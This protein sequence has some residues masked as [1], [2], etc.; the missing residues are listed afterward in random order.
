M[1]LLAQITCRLEDE[2][3]RTPTTAAIIVVSVGAVT[4]S[5]TRRVLRRMLGLCLANGRR[6]VWY[7]STQRFTAAAE[8]DDCAQS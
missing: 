3:Q 6:S 5:T 4:S 1:D 7:R 2:G 8:A